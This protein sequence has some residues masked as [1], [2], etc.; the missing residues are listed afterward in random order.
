M[1]LMTKKILS[2]IPARAGSKGIKDKN[3]VNICGK[4]LIAYTIKASLGSSYITDTI[5]SSDSNKILDISK[6]YGAMT[7]KRPLEYATDFASSESVVFHTIKF[8]E[9]SGKYYDY[10]ILLQPTSPLRDSNDIDSAIKKLYEKNADALISVKEV[11]NK[12]LKAFIEDENGNLQ[13]IANNTY[14]FMPRQ[15]LPKTFMSNGA[16]YIIKTDIFKRKKSFYSEMTIP[17]LMSQDKS[18]DIDTYDDLEFLRQ[19]LCEK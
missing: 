1:G 17:F 11:D 15:K 8:L 7:I 6:T 2:I 4:P 12:I 13:G 10:I 9:K 3:I 16:I 5:V 18:L 19:I 14:P